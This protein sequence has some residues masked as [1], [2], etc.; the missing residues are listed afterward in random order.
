[1]PSIP[2]FVSRACFSS[3][4]STTDKTVVIALTFTDPTPLSGISLI[5]MRLGS[6]LPVD[7][8]VPP[9]EVILAPNVRSEVIN[10]L[11]ASSVSESP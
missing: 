8:S 10:Q 9:T 2:S 7:V 3:A 6:S 1:M 5:R 11:P 4:V